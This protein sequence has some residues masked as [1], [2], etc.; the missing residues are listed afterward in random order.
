MWTRLNDAAKYVT[1]QPLPQ[2]NS[3]IAKELRVIKVLAVLANTIHDCLLQPTYQPPDES[4]T[5]SQVLYNLAC[6]EPRQENM[7][8]GMLLAALADQ[9]D[10]AEDQLSEHIVEEVMRSHGVEDVIRPEQ[11]IGFQNELTNMLDGVMDIWYKV[12]HS[13]QV[14]QSNFTPVHGTQVAHFI[15]KTVG[16][17]TDNSSRSEVHEDDNESVMLFPTLVLLGKQQIPVTAGTVIRKSLIA[18]LIREEWR[19]ARVGEPANVPRPRLKSRALS[20]SSSARSGRAKE[21]S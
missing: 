4:I 11:H 8:R 15:L 5:L 3:E 19:T 7:L 9:R 10:S 13:T 12:Q 17:E 6:I 14:F 2:S 20:M 1:E 16:P 18:S 21:F